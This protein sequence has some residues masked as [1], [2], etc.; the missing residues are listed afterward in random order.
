M[1][2]QTGLSLEKL[3]RHFDK[4][5]PTIIKALKFSEASNVSMEGSSDNDD[6]A[7]E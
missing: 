2:S 6:H 4:S 5:K 3:A 1:R 7:T